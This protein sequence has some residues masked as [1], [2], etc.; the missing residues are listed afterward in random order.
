MKGIKIGIVGVCISLIGI[1]L[2]ACTA[3]P[4]VNTTQY[5]AAVLSGG[6]EILTVMPLFDEKEYNGNALTL[7]YAA[8][9]F[10]AGDHIQVS[11]DEGFIDKPSAIAHIGKIFAL[12][13]T[14]PEGEATV[15]HDNSE[16]AVL[17]FVLPPEW[18]CSQSFDENNTTTLHISR[19][20]E[21]R[22]TNPFEIV[23][24]HFSEEGIYSRIDYDANQEISDVTLMSGL[25]AKLCS[26]PNRHE[27][28]EFFL[29]TDISFYDT[30]SVEPPYSVIISVSCPLAYWEAG[31]KD[32]IYAFLN[33]IAL[34]N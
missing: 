11:Y 32:M 33:S 16:N 19:K 7:T 14:L 27:P 30:T 9:E 25:C 26:Y 34:L 6:S 23:I 20:D 1:S 21:N 8:A 17:S 13:N 5:E 29:E 24:A 22:S 15:I 4:T 18:N 28:I 10:F 3:V 12:T 31:Y 2:S